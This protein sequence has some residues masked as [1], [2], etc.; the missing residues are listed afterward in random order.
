MNCLV[1]ESYY[2]VKFCEL[3]DGILLMNESMFVI[4]FKNICCIVVYKCFVG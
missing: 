1:W 3:M 4:D 2:G